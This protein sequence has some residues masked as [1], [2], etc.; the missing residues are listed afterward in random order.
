MKA[1]TK[2]VRVL[3]VLLCG[4]PAARLHASE[5]VAG[6]RLYVLDCGAMTIRDMG[7]FSDTGKYDGQSGRIVDTCFL[8]RHPKG[9]LLW[10]TG[11]GDALVGHDVPAN[12]DGV[13]LHVERG[14][15]DQ[16]AQIGNTRRCHLPGVLALSSGPYRQCQRLRLFDLDP[17]PGGARLGAPQSAAADRQCRQLQRL[18]FR[19]YDHDPLGLRRV[20]RRLGAYPEDAGHTPGHQVLLVKLSKSGA[21]LLSGISITCGRTARG[22]G[23]RCAGHASE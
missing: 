20:R 12:A 8:I 21:V 1:S 5:P 17:E 19:T 4:W 13:A 16:L 6:V 3:A 10:D 7:L 22:V 23:R 14:L 11:L 9:N 18:S 15:L 2:L